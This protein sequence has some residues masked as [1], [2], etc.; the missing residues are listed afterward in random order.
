MTTSADCAARAAAQLR[1][2]ARDVAL[3]AERRTRCAVQHEA[4]GNGA[5]GPA[6]GFC[7]PGCVPPD[8]VARD[9]RWPERWPL[10]THLELA[11]LDTAPGSARAHVRAVLREWHEWH[12]GGDAAETAALIVSELLTNA[13]ESTREHRRHDPVRLWVLGD[14]SSVLFLVWDS[15]AR[16]PVL[17]VPAP[18][19]EHGRGLTLV[20]DLCE[21][22]GH[23]YPAEQPFGKV[24]WALLHAAPGIWPPT[25]GPP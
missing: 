5:A 9:H 11:A 22:W 4:T 21:Q 3:V 10:R 14:R 2:A 25:S 8:L 15:T 12:A 1:E 17:T 19:D 20:N 6:A 24:V 18:G 16:P 13:I 7:T 23:Y